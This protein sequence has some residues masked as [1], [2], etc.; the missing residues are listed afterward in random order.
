MAGKENLT[1]GNGAIV[2]WYRNPDYHPSETTTS[3][4]SVATGNVTNSAPS[5]ATLLS[6][7]HITFYSAAA[8]ENGGN[9]GRNASSEYNNGYLAPGQAASS[10]LPL[11]TVVYIQTQ[12]SG[13]ASYANGKYFL[14]TDRGAGKIDGD[15]NLD[16]F[17]D[18]SNP[19]D[20]NSA[21]YGSSSSAKIYKVD[22]N[23]SW[24]T[25]KAKYGW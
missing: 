19:S 15:Y 24:E 21:P 1:F 2:R 3:V 10:Y 12:S 16:I 8:S 13:E 9:A 25:F 23:V 5:G 22:E 20:N 7:H 4:A 11:G 17:H 6:D 14:I 18:V